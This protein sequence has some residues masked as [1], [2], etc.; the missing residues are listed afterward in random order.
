MENIRKLTAT[1]THK[2]ENFV[3]ELMCHWCCAVFGYP[4]KPLTK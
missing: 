4:P 1:E 3:W 2:R